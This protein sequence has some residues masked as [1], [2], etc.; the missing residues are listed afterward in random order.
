ML[1]LFST[2]FKYNRKNGQKQNLD[3]L[4]NIL[5]LGIVGGTNIKVMADGG[6]NPVMDLT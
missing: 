5:S 3:I 4:P 1:Y 6:V 2:F